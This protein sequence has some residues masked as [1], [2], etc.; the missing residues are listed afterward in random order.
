MIEKT[1]HEAMPE[2]RQLRAFVAVAEA[3]HFGRAA[4]ALHVSQPTLSQQVA[5]LERQLGTRLL[6]RD[7]R[8]VALTETGRLVLDEARAALAAAARVAAVARCAGAGAA[9][10]LVIGYAP[11]ADCAVF[12]ARLRAFR[13]RN[14]AVTVDLQALGSSEQVAALGAGRIALGFVRLPVDAGPEVQVETLDEED[15][16]VALPT[17]HPLATRRAIP[18]AALAGQPFVHPPRAQAP[19][20]YD[21]LNAVCREAGFSPAVA[22]EADHSQAV[23]GL[24]A[25]GIGVAL[26]PASARQLRRAGVVLRPLAKPLRVRTGLI[27]RRGDPS[28]LLANFLAVLRR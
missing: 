10:R 3:L 25:G 18:L 14:P 1:N 26:V 22:M 12:T 5:G 28:P 20:F 2:L 6:V 19:G 27:Q 24:V 8:S 15:L 17:R 16:V 11:S 4:A 21:W 23:L 13:E 7:R 9:G